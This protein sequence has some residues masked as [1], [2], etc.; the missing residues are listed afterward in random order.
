MIIL[1]N[2]GYSC[3]AYTIFAHRSGEDVYINYQLRWA[4]RGGHLDI[5][6]YLVSVGAD[7]HDC[8]P[9]AALCHAAANGHLDVVKYLISLGAD[10]HAEDDGALRWAERNKHTEVAEY[11]RGYI[12]R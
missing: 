11:L 1:E 6:K 5:V 10:V 8:Y 7:I 3:L 4:A 2:S 9:H 12:N